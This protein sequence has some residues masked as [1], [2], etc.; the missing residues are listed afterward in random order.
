[1]PSMPIRAL[2]FVSSFAPLLFAMGVLD[3]FGKGWVSIALYAA[4]ALGLVVVGGGVL[5]AERAGRDQ[6]R[7]DSST[8]RDADMLS[9]VVTYLL[10]FLGLSVHT[11]RERVAVAV[12]FAMLAVL[13]IQ[14]GLFYVNPLLG[15]FGLRLFDVESGGDRYVLLTRRTEVPS[16][17]TVIY[18]R[19]SSRVLVEVRPSGV[20]R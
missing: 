19:V 2:L 5:L 6:M 3:S 13:Y 15:L 8:A 20:G 17:F 9:Y 14:A 18:R 7:I 1:M 10:P 16:N 4:S 12:V 11:G